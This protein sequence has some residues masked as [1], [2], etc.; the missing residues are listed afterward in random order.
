MLGYPNL[1]VFDPE[2]NVVQELT[3]YTTGKPVTYFNE[4]KEIVMPVVATVE[5]RKKELRMKGFRD[6]TNREGNHLFARFVRHGGGLVTLQGANLETWTIE[7]DTLNPAD[8]ALVKSFP[9]VGEA[10]PAEGRVAGP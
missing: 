6:W 3:G 7:I 9:E 5:E 4:L 8:Q 2:G 10:K 1:L